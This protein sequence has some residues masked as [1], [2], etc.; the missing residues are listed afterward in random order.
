MALTIVVI[1]AGEMGA[2][3]GA[4]LVARGASVRTSLKGRGGASAERARKAGM[5]PVES[6]RALLDGADIVLSIVPPGVAMAFAERMAPVLAELPRK[7]IFADCNAVAPETMH[8]IAAKIVPSGAPV[9]DVG[10]IGP[11]P[12]GEGPSPRLYASG[13]AAERLL[14]LR[15]LGL[16]VR[17]VEGGIGAA[18]ALKMSYAMLNKGAT[19]LGTAMILAATRDGVAD[20]LF[21][22]LSA[23]QPALFAYL[24]AQVPRMPPK[25]YRWV[26]EMEEIA[27]FLGGPSDGGPI[28]EGVARFYDRIAKDVAGGDQDRTI[29]SDF[30]Q[31][32]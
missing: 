32:G 20:D 9:A 19:A 30:L 15:D 8:A 6:D 18:S 14:A 25:A 2:G 29:L 23:S 3:I 7:P 28:Y 12:A 26:A 21:A 24:K 5:E 1:A 13:E 4:R 31:R 17:L 16:D 11:P 22:E 27:A 10:I